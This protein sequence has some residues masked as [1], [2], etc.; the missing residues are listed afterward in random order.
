[1]N[2]KNKKVLVVGLAKTGVSLCRFLT[3][4]GAR[5]TAVDVAEEEDLGPPARE[6]ASMGI[7]L[8][9]GPHRTETFCG[10][11]LIVVS[12]G[13]ANNI[14][15]IEAARSAGI[16]VIGELE[17]AARYIN[18]PIAAVT[19]TNGKTTTTSL[20][21]EM[22]RQSGLNVFVG[23]NIGT[24]LIDYAGSPMTADVVVA[25]VSS[26]QLDTIQTFRPKV[27]VLLNVTEDHLDRYRHFR[28]YVASKARL[29][30]NQTSSDVAVLNRAD[31]VT[32]RLESGLRAQKVYF[33]ITSKAQGDPLP[34]TLPA[35]PFY[36]AEVRGNEMICRLPNDVPVTFNLAHLKMKGAHNLE[37]AA[38]A[39]LAALAAGGSRTGIQKALETFRGLPHRLEHVRTI[40]GVRYYNDSKATNVGA[41]MRALES[42]DTPVILIMGGRD[43]G[44]SYEGLCEL[45][46]RLVKK[47]ITIGEAS[48]KIAEA[49][50]GL[51]DSQT[52][53]SLQQAVRLAG[54]VASPGDVVLLSPGCSSFDMFADYAERGEAFRQAVE[55]LR[56]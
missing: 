8:E 41:V 52:A 19:G 12:P 4:Q 6:A 35:T 21:G 43:K 38:A 42:F 3:R 32:A 56:R 26:F 18:E 27:G 50:G 22:L 20:L 53:I 46:K 45:I 48:E 39:S 49:L 2:L 15:P 10:C 25:E 14:K 9:L 28:E 5:V 34:R 23:G 17:L 47:L 40:N 44:G 33:N 7:A 51:T 37:N 1:M 13:V 31:P 36:G 16:P 29:F 24:P 54:H 30:R 55:G 11:D